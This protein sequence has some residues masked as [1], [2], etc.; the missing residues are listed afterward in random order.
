MIAAAKIARRVKALCT[1]NR[2]SEPGNAFVMAFWDPAR[3]EVV[4]WRH[5]LA[6]QG[7]MNI[8]DDAKRILND[9]YPATKKPASEPHG[10]V[11]FYVSLSYFSAN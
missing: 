6:P 4:V 2:L 7:A 11:D 1:F 10:K 8:L 5:N 9:N 3:N